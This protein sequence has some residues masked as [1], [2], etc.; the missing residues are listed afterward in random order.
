MELQIS[1]L[2]PVI[3]FLSGTHLPFLESLN[4]A[5]PE[6]IEPIHD[7]PRPA[8]LTVLLPVCTFPALRTLVLENCTIFSREELVNAPAML[9]PQLKSLVI[10]CMGVNPL[11]WALQPRPFRDGADRPSIFELLSVADLRHLTLLQPF[12]AL[13]RVAPP[14]EAAIPTSLER[15]SLTMR[16]DRRK[17][18]YIDFVR[19]FHLASNPRIELDL[20]ILRPARRFRRQLC[21]KKK[22]ALLR[23]FYELLG[24]ERPPFELTISFSPATTTLTN[25]RSRRNTHIDILVKQKKGYTPSTHFTLEDHSRNDMFADLPLEQLEILTLDVTHDAHLHVS[26]VWWRKCFAKAKN[27]REVRVM[28][29]FESAFALVRVLSAEISDVDVARRSEG[30][31]EAGDVGDAV[32]KND[33]VSEGTANAAQS[34][35]QSRRNPSFRAS[36][37]YSSTTSTAEPRN[38]RLWDGGAY[39]HSRNW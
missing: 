37:S 1:A 3:P 33:S 15:L 4:I 23:H 13:F 19:S 10:D 7:F 18:K 30:A 22:D 12:P 8:R 36:S 34:K 25:P 9:F 5:A 31:G 29:G 16:Q 35:T 11:Y 26:D 20:H 38:H 27:V 17:M 39:A 2:R 6:E 21:F 24:T 28:G 32:N 14:E